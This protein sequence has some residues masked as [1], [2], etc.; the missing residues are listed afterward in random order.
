M[1]ASL[2]GHDLCTA[3]YLSNRFT[4]SFHIWVLVFKFSSVFATQSP[5]N[6]LEF[7]KAFDCPRMF[8]LF[9]QS[10]FTSYGFSEMFFNCIGVRG[11][12]L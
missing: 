5:F 9:S 10:W 7:R 11:G 3:P 1:T 12:A 6:S 2:S 8:D 4:F